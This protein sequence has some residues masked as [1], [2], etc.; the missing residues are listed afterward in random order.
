MTVSK[1][2]SVR[3]AVELYAVGEEFTV[4][5][6]MHSIKNRNAVITHGTATNI[7]RSFDDVRMI[8]RRSGKGIWVRVRP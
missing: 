1:R 3:R 5:E 7:L 2:T 4:S 8:D 6:L